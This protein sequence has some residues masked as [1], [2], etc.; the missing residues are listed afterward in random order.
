MK[1]KNLLKGCGVAAIVVV[2][3]VLSV[4]IS[5]CIEDE[6]KKHNDLGVSYYD[7]GNFEEAEKE[8]REA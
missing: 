1:G 3:I 4:L 5:G 6:A 2:G 8:F 7:S